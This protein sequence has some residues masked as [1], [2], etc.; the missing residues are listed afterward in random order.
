MR[1]L[2]VFMMA[3]CLSAAEPD[4]GSIEKHA[5]ELLQQYIRIASVN[6]PANTA[7]AAKF[8]QAELERNGLKPTL[9]ASGPG[10]QTNLVVRLKGRDP[11][12][13]PLLL[14]N[15]FDVVPVDPTAWDVDPFGGIVRDGFIWGRG[16]L[17]MKGIAVQ[18][19]TALIALHKAG[20]APA[21]DI[22]M[23]STADEET[24]GE[25][26]MNWMIANHYPEIDAEYVLDE[27]GLGSRDALASNKL[28]FGISV[29]D[30]VI[31]WLRMRAK[32]TA[33]HGSQPIPDNANM[34]LLRAID[35][36]LAVPE[37]GKQNAVV[38]QMKAD[39]GVPLAKNKFTSAIERNTISLTTLSAGVGS[40][41]KVNVIPSMSEATLDC[42]LLPGTNS[43]EFLSDI[44]ARIND[45]RVTVEAVY[46]SPDPG[47]SRSDT[48]LFASLRTAILKYHPE[49][50][51]TPML[52]PFG[53]DSAMLQKRG[54]VA[55]GFTP[56]VLDT[57]TA[58]TMHSDRERI[59]LTE[60][61]KGIHI[62]FDVLASDF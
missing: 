41:P 37:G 62:F 22:V 35:K 14:L 9:Y 50:V 18:Q 23:L 46:R 60:F 53:T 32:G 27:G 33:G 17:D 7:A 59:P 21:R 38:A 52:V 30:K 40:P 54:V 51:V 42:R 36:A 55:Y 5:V 48:P 19:L 13:K 11:S 10:G 28:V 34:I 44:K 24:G 47:M 39:I 61:L 8:I 15:H 25:L 20:V 16:A 29:G 56:M 49:A 3:G 58:A 45:P 43:D 57:A 31:L 6:P 26:G 12:K 2:L 4:W 1:T